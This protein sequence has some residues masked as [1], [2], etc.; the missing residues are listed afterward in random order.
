MLLSIYNYL[1]NIVDAL[2][3]CLM[4]VLMAVRKVTSTRKGILTACGANGH[5]NRLFGLAAT[6]F[7][8]LAQI[9]QS[10]DKNSICRVA[11]KLTEIRIDF[12]L[13]L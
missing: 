13:A 12:L 11:R 9:S 6:T 8:R 2:L 7:F 5:I 1:P 3:K 4:D 10:S